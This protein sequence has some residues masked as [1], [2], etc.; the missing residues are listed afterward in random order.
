VRRSRSLPRSAPW[1]Q[2]TLISCDRLRHRP[3]LLLGHFAA[4]APHAVSEA[5]SGFPWAS[6]LHV[7]RGATTVAPT[8]LSRRRQEIALLA[9]FRGNAA[10]RRS[11]AAAKA[12]LGT[13]TPQKGAAIRPEQSPPRLPFASM[14]AKECFDRHCCF[15]RP[16]H[17]EQV[18][19]ID[20]LQSGIWNEPRQNAAVDRRHQERRRNR[21]AQRLLRFLGCLKFRVCQPSEARRASRP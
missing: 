19:I 10:G 7:A 1:H 6:L 5:R 13:H 14:V 12:A 15:D 18:S 11:D 8:Q 21:Q 2:R 4:G 17:H 9:D 3:S 20:H 16:R